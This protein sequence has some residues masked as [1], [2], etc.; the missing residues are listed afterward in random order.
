MEMDLE[1][2]TRSIDRMSSR[3]VSSA[4][5]AVVNNQQNNN[6]SQL[7]IFNRRQEDSVSST[8]EWKDRMSLFVEAYMPELSKEIHE[9]GFDISQEGFSDLFVTATQSYHDKRNN[10]MIFQILSSIDAN[11]VSAEGLKKIGK[12]LSL[13]SFI[14]STMPEKARIKIENLWTP[15]LA[16]ATER[17]NMEKASLDW[18][19]SAPPAVAAACRPV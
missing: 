6:L 13:F 12:N 2:S 15:L 11:F 4:M 9:L 1:T 7:S 17:K 10:A 19:S 5:S 14:H 18:V 8:S 16:R 3:P